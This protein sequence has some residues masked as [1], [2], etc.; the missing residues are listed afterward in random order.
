MIGTLKYLYIRI[1][2]TTYGKEIIIGRKKQQEDK[3]E[4]C[5]ICIIILIIEL[6]HGDKN[7][8]NQHCK[9]LTEKG[10]AFSNNLTKPILLYFYIVRKIN[11]KSRL[12]FTVI[13][14]IYSFIK[15]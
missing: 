1:L 13:K 3:F 15:Y 11:E 12:P 5:E 2:G 4:N 7:V 6:P 8:E 9:I 10:F 14:H